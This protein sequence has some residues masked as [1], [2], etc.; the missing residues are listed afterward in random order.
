LTSIQRQREILQC[1]SLKV[2]G[3]HDLV[4][5]LSFVKGSPLDPGSVELTFSELFESNVF[6]KP[7]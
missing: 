7:V 1:L 5:R 6:L 3:D 2:Q 4:V